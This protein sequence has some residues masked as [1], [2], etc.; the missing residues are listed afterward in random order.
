MLL[1]MKKTF[2]SITNGQNW[3]NQGFVTDCGG[4][5]CWAYSHSL[6]IHCLSNPAL[7]QPNGKQ[8]EDFQFLPVSEVLGPGTSTSLMTY[9]DSLY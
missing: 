5:C 1:H 8:A 4:S 6:V 3:P 9:K 2:F 7:S